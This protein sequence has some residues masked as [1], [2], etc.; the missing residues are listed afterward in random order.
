MFFRTVT[1]RAIAVVTAP[2]QQQQCRRMMSTAV[3]SR[4]ST[5]SNSSNKNNNVLLGLISSSFLWLPS[6]MMVTLCE[7]K[8]FLDKIVKKD[9]EGNTDWAKSASQIT[10]ADFWDKIATASGD[11]V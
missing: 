2:S 1:S 10:E 9:A 3:V 8:S 11:K 4:R 5:N 7:D 6:G